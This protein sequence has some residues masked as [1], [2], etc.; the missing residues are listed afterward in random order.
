MD[1]LGLM[2]SLEQN[3][4]CPP[5]LCLPGLG[6]GTVWKGHGEHRGGNVGAELVLSVVPS[7]EWADGRLLQGLCGHCAAAAEVPLHQ[8]QPAGQR[9]EH[10]PHDGCPGRS[11]LCLALAQ[12][13][14]VTPLRKGC[15]PPRA[16]PKNPKTI[17][18]E[19]RGPEG[20]V[21]SATSTVYLST[22]LKLMQK[23]QFLQRCSLKGAVWSG[24][25]GL[26][27]PR[28]HQESSRTRRDLPAPRL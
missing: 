7:P 2:Q 11:A 22:A 21:T 17:C 20:C 9:W 16:S 19:S 6:G 4:V 1:L 25:A 26:E 14:P 24:R 5:V 23:C 8:R 3:L 27:L 10:G 12:A 28:E 18:H 13:A 15:D